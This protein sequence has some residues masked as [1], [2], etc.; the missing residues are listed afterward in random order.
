[1][2]D[3]GHGNE[4]IVLEQY[5][6]YP[7]GKTPYVAQEVIT[8]QDVAFMMN[9]DA[10]TLDDIAEDLREIRELWFSGQD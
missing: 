4:C 7:L 6:V 5:R 2:T 1:M 9:P 3:E 8:P 10:I